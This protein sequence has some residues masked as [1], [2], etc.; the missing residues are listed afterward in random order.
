[1]TS[2]TVPAI[3]VAARLGALQGMRLVAAAVAFAAL[4]SRHGM[5]TPAAAL[6][7]LWVLL[8]SIGEVVRQVRRAPARGVGAL[9]VIDAIVLAVAADATGGPRSPV[10]AIVYLHVVLVSSLISTVMGLRIAVLHAFALYVAH[11]ATAANPGAAPTGL[12]ATHAAGYLLVAAGSA[13]CNH[14]HAK[15]ATWGRAEVRALADLGPRLASA[16]SADGVAA[17]LANVVVNDLGFARVAVL[18]RSTTGWRSQ[19]GEGETVELGDALDHDRTMTAALT[20]LGPITR[21]QLP[22]DSPLDR[23]IAAATDVAIVGVD[24][25]PALVVVAEWNLSRGHALR[26]ETLAA[27]TEAANHA[28]LAMSTTALRDQLQRLATH[29]GLTGLVNRATFDQKLAEALSDRRAQPVSIALVD[30]DHFKAVND[31]HGHQVGDE[32]LRRAADAMRAVARPGDITARYGGEELV[33]VLP[34]CDAEGAA[35]VAERLRESIAESGADPVV[36]A[37]IGVASGGCDT[38][39]SEVLAAADRA[40]YQAKRS[41]RDRVVVAGQHRARSRSAPTPQRRPA[42]SRSDQIRAAAIGARES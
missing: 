24:S 3:T 10:L 38:P 17:D 29:D 11:A 18:H 41:G 39:P 40:L 27:L 12:A 19:P 6:V 30:L 20:S 34:R 28:A 22:A 31:L 9:L 8:S 36:T 32:V 26:A 37:S 13:F 33:V 4:S 7:A 25:E 15:A 14:L 16:T 21:R 35:Q 42:R 1:M 5:A 2:K 23:L